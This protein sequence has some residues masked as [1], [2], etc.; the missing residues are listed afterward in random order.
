MRRHG[1]LKRFPCLFCVLGLVKAVKEGDPPGHS[2]EDWRKA[3]E[4][5]KF[6]GRIVTVKPKTHQDVDGLDFVSI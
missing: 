5:A 4:A 2:G 6:V 1:S 3:Q